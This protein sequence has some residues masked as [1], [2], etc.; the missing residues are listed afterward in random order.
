MR[1]RLLIWGLLLLAVLG[2]YATVT[3]A[4]ALVNNGTNG[5]IHYGTNGKV[6]YAPP[7]PTSGI[8]FSTHP[9]IASACTGSRNTK[10][11]GLMQAI[12]ATWQR[13]DFYWTDIQPTGSSDQVF[14]NYDCMV[15]DATAAGITTVA[16][17]Q[18]F[19]PQWAAW[20]GCTSGASNCAPDNNADFSQ[21]CTKVAT[22]FNGTIVNYEI[23]N[24]I[25]GNGNWAPAATSSD[26]AARFNACATAI[27]AV[28][29]SDIVIA[30]AMN[31]TFGAW[32]G[33]NWQTFID[34]AITAG[35]NPDAWAS[36]P[37]TY[38]LDANDIAWGWSGTTNGQ[39]YGLRRSMNT[40]GWSA[41]K[42]WITE[43]GAPTIGAR[44]A[45]GTRLASRPPHRSVRAELP[46]TAPA[47]SHDARR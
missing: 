2:A 32:N 33:I 43:Y 25:N 10:T 36:H 18:T 7:L 8:G 20:P 37:Y 21:F 44:V 28:N 4:D 3:H 14:T 6:T 35:I 42:I 40:A 41:K 23:G 38:S 39:V 31:G 34:G 9:T 46:H 5:Q 12:G 11:Y 29:A 19:A 27:H 15:N 16:L 13:T 47:S 45:V 1:L 24:E 22:H 26:Y 17:V 30:A